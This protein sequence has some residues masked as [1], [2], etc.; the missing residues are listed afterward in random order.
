MSSP[1]QRADVLT[2][3]TNVTRLSMQIIPV[4]RV[5]SHISPFGHVAS[6][7]GICIKSINPLESPER[8]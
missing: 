8:F 4:G 3:P 2:P 5:R 1:R 7:H 6:G